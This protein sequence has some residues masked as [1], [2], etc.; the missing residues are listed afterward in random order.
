MLDDEEMSIVEFR[1]LLVD[2]LEQI[3]DYLTSINQPQ[4]VWNDGYTIQINK[5]QDITR[6]N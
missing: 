4:H 3:D 6:W 2:V 5:M 1:D